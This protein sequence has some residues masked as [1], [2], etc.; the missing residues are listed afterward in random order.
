MQAPLEHTLGGYTINYRIKYQTTE[1]PTSTRSHFETPTLTGPTITL[2]DV[3]Q[4]IV[5]VTSYP[6]QIHR[7]ESAALGFQLRNDGVIPYS[8]VQV[9][10]QGIF[11]SLDQGLW[12][13]ASGNIGKT[14]PVDIAPGDLA[15]VETR[16]QASLD[17][18][19][20]GYTIKYR[21]KYETAEYPTST[22]SSFETP[23]YMGLTVNVVE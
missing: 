17:H 18:T 8:G 13:P 16:M 15:W 10:V 5:V 19:L 22:R 20:G 6:S 12:L 11:I 21:L 1:Y 9:L 2:L 4:D 7:G 14:S 23:T 3:N